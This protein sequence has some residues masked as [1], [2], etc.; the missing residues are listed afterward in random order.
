MHI[1]CLRA[2]SPISLAAIGLSRVQLN[3]NTLCAGLLRA[4]HD[5]GEG[6]T[7]GVHPRH[8]ESAL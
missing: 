8:R 5:S 4:L 7:T 6:T 1:Y 3:F 2:F